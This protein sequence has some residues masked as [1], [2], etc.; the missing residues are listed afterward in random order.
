MLLLAERRGSVGRG[1]LLMWIYEKRLQY[2]VPCEDHKNLSEDGAAYHQ[3]IW[4]AGRG[5]VRFHAVP[6]PALYHAP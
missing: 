6:F 3:P 4:R 2:P 1:V 5:I